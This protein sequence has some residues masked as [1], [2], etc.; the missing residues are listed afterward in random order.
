MNDLN[1]MI[2][3]IQHLL[4]F[5]MAQPPLTYIAEIACVVNIINQATIYIISVTPCYPSRIW[6]ASNS[7]LRLPLRGWPLLFVCRLDISCICGHKLNR[8]F[9][10]HM[11][12][13]S[14]RRSYNNLYGLENHMLGHYFLKSYIQNVPKP[15]IYMS[16]NES[17]T[18]HFETFCKKGI[19]GNSSVLI[20]VQ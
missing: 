10:F 14:H 5:L 9:I 13:I 7:G 8:M 2:L 11:L 12:L 3:I 18:F 17:K 4:I 19:F 6:Q 1:D 15:V 20:H 16:I